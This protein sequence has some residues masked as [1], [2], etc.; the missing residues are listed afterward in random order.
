MNSIWAVLFV[1]F[2]T[3]LTKW[4]LWDDDSPE[5]Q[6]ESPVL[7]IAETPPDPQPAPLSKSA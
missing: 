7:H 3:L 5:L 2:A 1:A 4:L 6:T